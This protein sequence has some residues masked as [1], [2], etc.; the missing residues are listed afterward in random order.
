[1]ACDTFL[2]TNET[3]AVVVAGLLESSFFFFSSNL[4]LGHRRN[5]VTF[6]DVGIRG[7]AGGT[8]EGF[9]VL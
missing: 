9:L 4:P 2:S 8:E 7:M 5:N 3:D 6:V 1:M